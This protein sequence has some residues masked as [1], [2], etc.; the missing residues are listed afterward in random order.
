[1]RFSARWTVKL[2]QAVGTAFCEGR[3]TRS[4]RFSTPLKQVADFLLSEKGPT[5][6]ATSPDP[7]KVSVKGQYSFSGERSRGQPRPEHHLDA[8]EK[9]HQGT[10]AKVGADQLD[11]GVRGHRY[12]GGHT[13]LCH[14]S[15][16]L[17]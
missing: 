13:L 6:D 11:S 10:S 7:Q 5:V 8:A 17:H 12:T 2:I 16:M 14:S 9:K 3:S 1:M 4:D 15:V